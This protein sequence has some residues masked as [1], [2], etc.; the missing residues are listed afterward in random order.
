MM[1]VIRQVIALTN[2]RFRDSDCKMVRCG[3]CMVLSVYL[4]G[5]FQFFD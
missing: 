2:E 3:Y 4:F 1:T 5:G